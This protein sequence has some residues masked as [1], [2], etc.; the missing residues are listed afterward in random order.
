M[1]ENSKFK[2]VMV[3]SGSEIAFPENFISANKIAQTTLID[4]NNSTFQSAVTETFERL[5][6]IN[7]PSVEAY[8]IVNRDNPKSGGIYISD[9]LG[10]DRGITITENNPL[11]VDEIRGRDNYV[12]DSYYCIAL[13]AG[14]IDIGHN[15]HSNLLHISTEGITV[16]DNATVQLPANTIIGRGSN[17][18][19]GSLTIALDYGRAWEFKN[20]TICNL[21]MYCDSEI[22]TNNVRDGGNGYSTIELIAKKYS[23]GSLTDSVSIGLDGS[24]Q[25]VNI[26]GTIKMGTYFTAPVY[27]EA[28]DG[29]Y[30][31]TNKTVSLR[32]VERDGAY[33]IVIDDN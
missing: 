11:F 30:T 5:G 15:T 24:T 26:N 25:T 27:T 3:N 10:S 21:D 23:E 22:K 19:H 17:T 32:V 12:N 18:S 9:P 29:S 8:Q 31:K 4:G 20:G 13:G 7:V 33:T 6:K 2:T 14:G 1:A 16:S 28:A